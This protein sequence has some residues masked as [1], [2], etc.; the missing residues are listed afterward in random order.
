MACYTITDLL[1]VVSVFRTYYAVV[2]LR[3]IKLSFLRHTPALVQLGAPARFVRTLTVTTI[4][5]A[6]Q[7]LYV[8]TSTLIG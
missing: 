7:S 6:L 3:I 1:T 4:F 2:G 8:W 5:A